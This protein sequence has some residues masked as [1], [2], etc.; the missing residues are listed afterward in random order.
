MVITR[1]ILILR[2]YIAKISLLLVNL[3]QTFVFHWKIAQCSAL[4]TGKDTE[5]QAKK[6]KF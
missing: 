6:Y 3:T 5:I 1:R 4:Y 2:N